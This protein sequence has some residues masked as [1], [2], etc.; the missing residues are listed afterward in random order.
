MD[1][2]SLKST[3]TA[4]KSELEMQTALLDGMDQDMDAVRGNLENET[5]HA[6]RVNANSSLCSLYMAILLLFIVMVLLLIIGL[7]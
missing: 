5:N 4:I 7:R 6:K 1:V 3:G 2:T